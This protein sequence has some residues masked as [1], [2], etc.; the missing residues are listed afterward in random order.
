MFSA[1]SW[2]LEHLISSLDIVREL[3]T[4]AWCIG[5]EGSVSKPKWEVHNWSNY[6]VIEEATGIFLYI[7]YPISCVMC[8]VSKYVG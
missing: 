5:T 6:S 3:I 7:T 1:V 2:S 8:V 4:K